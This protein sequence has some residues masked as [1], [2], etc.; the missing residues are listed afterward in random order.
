M[1]NTEID[2]NPFQDW[3][4]EQ[5]VDND[6]SLGTIV[7]ELALEYDIEISVPTLKRRLQAWGIRKQAKV[8]D[9]LE[10]RQ[11]IQ[12]LF[13]D[14]GLSDTDM[15][16][17]LQEEGFGI[18]RRKMAEIRRNMGL[19][20]RLIR[21]EID[22]AVTKL[23]QIFEKELDGTGDLATAKSFGIGFM[24]TYLNTLAID[25]KERNEKV[26]INR[27]GTVL[28]QIDPEGADARA[29]EVKATRHEFV[30]PGPN[31][32]W[33]VDGYCKLRFAGIEIYG[34]I[35]TYGRFVTQLYCGISNDT[36]VSILR[37]YI[38]AIETYGFMPLHLRSDRGP[39]TPMMA[40]AHYKIHNARRA[41][42]GLPLWLFSF[43]Y[44]FG[45]STANQRIEAWWAQLAKV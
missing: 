45:T 27:I 25:E 12:F 39:E 9:T 23:K 16:Y 41:K 40:D 24:H 14:V 34:M 20:R 32:C 38:D 36:A 29:K 26:T 21:D 42:E 17:V 8:D 13:K 22:M 18:E 15:H 19:R 3:I 37:Q 44:W 35:D 10:L 30:V 7:T 43:C 1:P 5:Y 11:R 4:R 28:R 31:Y 33:S 2:L 6:H